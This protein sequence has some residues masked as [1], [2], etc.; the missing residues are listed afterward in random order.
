MPRWCPEEY[1]AKYLDR[2]LE[3]IEDIQVD[4]RL[5]GAL[6]DLR[7]TAGID[8]NRVLKKIGDSLTPY[9]ASVFLISALGQGQVI[10]ND[11]NAET[12]A[13]KIAENPKDA[14]TTARLIRETKDVDK[15][16]DIFLDSICSPQGLSYAVDFLSSIRKE[17]SDV[18]KVTDALIAHS[19][20]RLVALM[21]R[22]DKDSLEKVR[23]KIKKAVLGQDDVSLVYMYF[24]TFK[25]D[26]SALRKYIEDKNIEDSAVWLGLAD[27]LESRVKESSIRRIVAGLRRI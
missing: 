8:L 26:V 20:D 12:L 1:R 5:S 2:I 24:K 7:H 9:T 21:H 4:S 10:L 13:R 23:G 14:Y 25:D 6:F 15:L 18:E 11:S 3:A 22:V 27:K 17:P 16:L 19:P